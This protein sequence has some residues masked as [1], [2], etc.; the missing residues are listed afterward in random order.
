MKPCV[1]RLLKKKT[2]CTRV[3]HTHLVVVMVRLVIVHGLMTFI[4]GGSQH[5]GLLPTSSGQAVV[6]GQQV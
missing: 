4:A 3:R 6:P 5:H 2:V 1:I